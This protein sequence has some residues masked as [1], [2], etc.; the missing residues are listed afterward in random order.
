GT[1]A[2]A[3]LDVGAEDVEGPHVE[4]DVCETA[5]QQGG[6]E[7]PPPLS[8]LHETALVSQILAHRVSEAL[9]GARHDQDGA[10]DGRD[11][12][13]HAS[14]LT[15]PDRLLATLT[16]HTLGAPLTDG[17]VDGARATDGTPA[18]AARETGFP[19]R[20]PVADPGC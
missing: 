20:M 7:Q 3:P 10:G 2:D 19:L 15:E 4:Q 1:R 16:A 5:V 8:R 9:R 11:A 18:L 13:R 14:W 6:G 17:R 12:R